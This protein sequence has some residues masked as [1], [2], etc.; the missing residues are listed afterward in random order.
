MQESP[1]RRPL[2][3]FE[4]PIYIPPLTLAT[5]LVDEYGIAGASVRHNNP[6]FSL[7]AAAAAT[8]E[9][10]AGFGATRSNHGQEA[11][12]PQSPEPYN[13]LGEFNAT[14]SYFFG[15]PPS[16][17]ILES[18]IAKGGYKLPQ[19]SGLLSPS[20]VARATPDEKPRSNPT[21][22]EEEGFETA[23]GSDDGSSADEDDNSA[24]G[25]SADGSS[26]VRDEALEEERRKEEERK[27]AEL[28]SR[29]R[30]VIKQQVA[31]ERMKE[32]HRR[33]YPG[34]QSS[35]GLHN[36]V[37]RWQKESAR[38]VGNISSIPSAQNMPKPQSVLYASNS[39]INRGGHASGTAQPSIQQPFGNVMGSGQR[40]AHSSGVIPGS[41]LHM[42]ANASSS[43]PNMTAYSM[44]FQQQPAQMH[45]HIQ[46]GFHQNAQDTVPIQVGAS[47]GG[48]IHPNHVLGVQADNT[49][50]QTMPVLHNSQVQVLNASSEPAVSALPH[51]VKLASTPKKIRNPYLSD[52]SDGSDATSTSSSGSSSDLPNGDNNSSDEIS[53]AGGSDISCESIPLVVDHK[54]RGFSNNNTDSARLKAESNVDS[55]AGDSEVGAAS[56]LH[57]T[58]SDSSSDASAKSQSS[59]K[60]RVRFHE[61]VSVVFNTRRSIAE[62]DTENDAYGSDSNSSD[63]SMDVSIDCIT[64]HQAANRSTSSHAETRSGNSNRGSADEAFDSENS[65]NHA[66]YY[67]PAFPSHAQLQGSGV[68]WLESDAKNA[69][70]SKSTS[71]QSSRNIS[72]DGVKSRGRRSS[73]RIKTEPL[74][75]HEAER[76]QQQQKQHQ[77]QKQ[78]Q[79]KMQQQAHAIGKQ[80]GKDNTAGSES[81]STS[82]SGSNYAATATIAKAAT[83]TSSSSVVGATEPAQPTVDRVAE[84]RRA[85]LGHYHTPNPSVPV[86]PGIPRNSGAKPAYTSS[87]KVVRPQSFSRPKKAYSRGGSAFSPE[88]PAERTRSFADRKNKPQG[89]NKMAGTP[90][91]ISK[92]KFLEEAPRED[93]HNSSQ[94]FE[95]SNVLQNFSIASFEVTKAK[96]GGMHINYSNRNKSQPSASSFK[97]D[98][99]DSEDDDDSDG[100]ELPLSAIV[101]SKS[102]PARYP[103]HRPVVSGEMPKRV[104]ASEAR[105]SRSSGNSTNNSPNT[106]P[107]LFGRASTDQSRRVLVRNQSLAKE[108]TAFDHVIGHNEMSRSVSM[109]GGPRNPHSQKK[110][111]EG[112][113]RFSRFGGFFS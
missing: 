18:Q 66:R 83:N 79:Q 9:K 61:T 74:R 57:K 73:S 99:A 76:E 38:A 29:R 68:S 63:A 87:V 19:D 112:K 48:N 98:G 71:E 45:D 102:E 106:S 78:R 47:G 32:R 22:S 17:S 52:S 65:L 24:D 82:Q 69:T 62:E 64:D 113:G 28:R 12:S 109:D 55:L 56:R 54:L 33:Q 110:H 72:P 23:V 5:T 46:H 94:E 111:N 101:R 14:Y 43:M 51:P 53:S 49:G 50:Y 4:D 36:N 20:S 104:I 85:L 97:R 77:D 96:D 37:A 25:S 86:G 39:T 7:A 67:I 34:Q 107:P 26:S 89:Q 93:D 59:S 90:D 92:H 31:F 16:E 3:N 35:S 41:L 105:V 13:F 6:A 80:V 10:L 42:G 70:S 103:A 81:N 8:P 58:V 88:K 91:T 84:A 40:G 44:Q 108:K 27:A 1:P 2:T 30:E 15:S 75:D 95:L 11:D 60:R 100:D 21:A